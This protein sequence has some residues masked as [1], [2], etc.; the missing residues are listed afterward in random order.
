MKLQ[1]KTNSLKGKMLAFILPLVIIS[2]LLL[3]IFGFYKSKASL[4]KN[5][6]EI[7]DSM[8]TIAAD[9]VNNELEG[10]KRK[11]HYISENLNNLGSEASIENKL[12]VLQ[13]YADDFTWISLGIADKDGNAK[14]TGNDE[15]VNIKD[16]NYFQKALSGENYIDDPIMSR[17]EKKM[18]VTYSMPLKNSNNET[19]GVLFGLRP[20]EELSEMVNK[21][22]FLKTGSAYLLDKEG[23]TIAH[24]D[25]SLVDNRQNLIK[26]KSNDPVYKELVAIEKNM[27]EGKDS[28]GSFSLNGKEKFIA[29]A[30]IKNTGWSL[31]V[32]VDRE[33][34]LSQ[35]S[36]LKYQFIVISLL[37]T[38]I[39]AVLV[40]LGSKKL[41]KP[42]EFA[43]KE[44]EKMS[45]GD[46]THSNDNNYSDLKD[47]I[48]EILNTMSKTKDAISSMIG[49]IKGSS[50][51]VDETATSLAAIS[52]ELSALTNNISI[53]IEEVAS[54][55]T[56]QASDLTNVVGKL[57]EFGEQIDEVSS[58]INT[59]SSMSSDIS[60]NSLQSKKDMRELI[61]SIAKF[62]KSFSKFTDSIELMNGDIK[63]VNEITDL[64]NNIA[65]QT[66]LLALNA[67]IEAA[68]A[69]ESGK[70][71]AVVAEE[72]RKL[73]E[74]SKESSQNIYTIV[75]N[76][77]NNTKTIVSETNLMNNELEIQKQSVE[78]SINSFN[79]IS[80]SVEEITPKINEINLA[81][82][83]INENKDGILVTIEELSSI[84]EE[85]SASAEEI[86][87]SSQE[88]NR[89]SGEVANSAQNL[90]SETNNML[91]QVEKFKIEE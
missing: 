20:L 47:E 22:K 80:S 13:K 25:K 5:S 24:K 7:T 73:A 68:R 91:S 67:A 40:I 52:E 21:I 79:D 70:G 45:N 35:L 57:N 34:V 65:E 6:S 59:I 17:T 51:E 29:Y 62:N 30:P 16:R 10:N 66:N 18:V 8:S 1:I 86:A 58:N 32:T 4:A 12:Q 42:L 64:I 56:K 82:K 71:F 69:G 84:S 38:L 27:V 53:A 44:T 72:I 19:I 90:S 76:L 43:K 50:T 83:D 36:S 11:L 74:Q 78:K 60:N 39:I 89:S 33:D 2:C 88:L 48:G 61:E 77:L 26:D 81:F 14:L 63:T 87:A 31:G 9:D 54:G 49:N 41:T 46:F 85:V 15:V 55:T 28:I 3:T 75:T 23:T 37:V